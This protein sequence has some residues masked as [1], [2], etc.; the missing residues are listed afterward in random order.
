MLPTLIGRV[1]HHHEGL[2]I[3]EINAVLRDEDIDLLTRMIGPI[4]RQARE[5]Q[6]SLESLMDTHLKRSRTDSESSVE[7]P[8]RVTRRKRE[9]SPVA[10]NTNALQLSGHVS[11]TSQIS[12]SGV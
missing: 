1:R 3:G 10:D 12:V 7:M 8:L 9:G 11:S 4:L 2:D 5:K 6:P